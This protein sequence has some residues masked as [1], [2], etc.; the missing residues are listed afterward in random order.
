[1]V[2]NAASLAEIRANMG[3][4]RELSTLQAAN[5]GTGVTDLNQVATTIANAITTAIGNIKSEINTQSAAFVCGD[6]SNNDY[7]TCDLNYSIGNDL[8]AS[9]SGIGVRTTGV[10]RMYAL[11]VPS[12]DNSAVRFFI[13]E[14][15]S[16]VLIPVLSGYAN[17][18]D[19]NIFM[20][21]NT[22]PNYFDLCLKAG[23][24]LKPKLLLASGQFYAMVSLVKLN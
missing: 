1:M 10:Y 17:R 7:I 11:A 2:T 13:E 4:G 5:G 14:A 3:L 8:T 16:R 6:G 21:Y 9:V 19:S 24:S 12:Q 20:H 22:S 15:S 18:Q 23:A